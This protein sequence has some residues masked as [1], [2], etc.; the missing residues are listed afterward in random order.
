MKARRVRSLSAA[1]FFVAAS[2]SAQEEIANW[3]AHALWNPPVKPAKEA[4]PGIEAIEGVPTPPLPFVALNPCRLVDT[5]GNGFTGS[6]GPPALVAG[7]PRSFVLTGRC[8]IS[9]TAQAVSLN[10]TV[11]NTQGP[12]HIVIYPTGGAQPTV[13]TLNYVGGQT[14]ANAAVVPLGTGGAITVVA[15][16]SGTDFILDTNGDYRGGVV[17]SLNGLFN[18]VNLAAG[19]NVTITPAG[20]TLTVAATGGP[21]GVLPVGS[22]DQTL[23]HNGSNWIASSA[24]RN[25]GMNVTITGVLD[26]PSLPNITLDDTFFFIH[27]PVDLSNTMVGRSAGTQ[28]GFAGT[29]N[30]GFGDR[31]CFSNTTGSNNTAVGAGALINNFSGSGNIAIGANVGSVLTS[32]SNNIYIGNPGSGNESGQIRI[33]T[34]ANI[35]Q[36]TV[37]VGIHGFGSSGG[38][39]VIVNSGGRLGTTTSS[40]RFKKDIR[41]IGT[42]SDDLMKLRPV[43]FRYRESHEAGRL[44]QYGLIAEEVAEVYPELVVN[45]DQGRPLA[46]R[47]QLLEPLFLNELQKQRRNQ[48]A[49]EATISRQGETIARQQADIEELRAA[50]ARL[51]ARIAKK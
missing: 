33:G 22:A 44:T 3:P 46:I 5:R 27:T 11:T 43:A 39:P 51:E 21:G 2:A 48:E 6:Y 50:L 31:A 12:G 16:V 35:T 40:A 7:V 47:S 8:G 41:S 24:L 28:P 32:G 14:I 38:I 19:S 1:V 26:L 10:V 49:D 30:T 17:T 15:G 18:G 42:E 29:G 37:I 36:G 9:A 4:G 20:Q 13:S 34:V 23:R 25:D 45:D